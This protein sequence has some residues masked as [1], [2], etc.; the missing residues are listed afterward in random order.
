MRDA[1]ERINWQKTL[2]EASFNKKGDIFKSIDKY[3]NSARSVYNAA[4]T[5]SDIYKMVHP[6]KENKEET[7]KWIEDVIRSGD[8]DK[9]KEY[10]SGLSTKQFEEAVKRINWNEKYDEKK[11]K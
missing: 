8:A 9:L 6:D 4:K 3:T 5:T 10:Q 7:P 1:I 2:E 11:K